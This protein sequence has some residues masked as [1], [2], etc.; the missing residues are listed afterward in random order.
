[1]PLQLTI[2]RRVQFSAA[3]RYARPEWDDARN[4]AVFGDNV[5]L[6][7]HNYVLEATVAGAVDPVTGMAA[8]IGRLDARLDALAERL[9]YR[10]LSE[11]PELAGEVPTTENL[12]LHAWREL[13][14]G[15]YGGGRLVRVR[16]FE[17]PEL[18]VEVSADGAAA[19]AA[20]EAA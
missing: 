17:S 16:L 15:D 12:A 3:H 6:H 11:A 20:T 5:N 18:F 19:S 8:D 14:G 2:T 4:R 7:G 9:G 10:D 13:A 1:M